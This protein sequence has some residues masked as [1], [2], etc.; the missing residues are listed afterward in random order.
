MNQNIEITVGDVKLRR[1]Q[2][3]EMEVSIPDGRYETIRE[4][5]TLTPQRY[6]DMRSA[7]DMMDLILCH[8]RHDGQHTETDN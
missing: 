7:I 6:K 2:T 5:V 3:G 4:C 8:A 1:T